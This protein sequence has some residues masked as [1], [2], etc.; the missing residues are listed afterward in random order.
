MLTTFDRKSDTVCVCLS[1]EL[2]FLNY[3]CEK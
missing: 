1:Y 3:M 2:E